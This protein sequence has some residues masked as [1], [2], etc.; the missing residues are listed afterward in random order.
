M[1]KF[2]NLF[3]ALFY[4]VLF[5]EIR[6]VYADD[7]YDK[8]R[9]ACSPKNSSCGIIVKCNEKLC[10][11]K[12]T[13]RIN[14]GFPEIIKPEYIQSIVVDKPNL[15]ISNKKFNDIEK[16]VET[17]L[18]IQNNSGI[19]RNHKVCYELQYENIN[20]SETRCGAVLACNNKN[21]QIRESHIK[22]SAI[23]ESGKELFSIAQ[24]PFS[25]RITREIEISK[26]HKNNSVLKDLLMWEL[27]TN[28]FTKLV[29]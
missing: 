29:L 17:I 6:L 7:N 24:I 22:V 21:C 11:I 26:I 5:C 18:I 19:K 3:A 20:R 25:A 10:E 23:I 16:E 1:N 14:N 9:L 13:H 15:Y 28:N 2:I 4:T 12:E 8:G 27:L